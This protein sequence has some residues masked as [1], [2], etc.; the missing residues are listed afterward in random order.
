MAVS[1]QRF[2]GKIASGFYIYKC[3]ALSVWQAILLA[4]SL[5][6]IAVD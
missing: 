6:C 1:Q 5:F 3:T 4:L 2:A